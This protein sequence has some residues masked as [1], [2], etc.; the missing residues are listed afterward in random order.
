MLVLEF[1]FPAGRYHATPWGRN[2]NEGEVEW[3]PSP[4]RLA[5]ALVDVCHRRRPDWPDE[6]LAAVLRPLAAPPAFRLPPAT[7]SHTRSFLNS[8]LKDPTAKQ[9]IFD[10]FVAVDRRERLLVAFDCHVPEDV[11]TDLGDLLG[12]MNYLGRSESWVQARVIESTDGA[13]FNCGMPGSVKT[14]DQAERVR[15]ACLMSEQ[16]YASLPGQ[17]RRKSKYEGKK[18]NASQPLSWLDAIR[19]STTGLLTDGWSQPPA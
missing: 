3:P 19:L 1:Q 9:K 10:A 15:V 18:A 16:E 2:V 11:K 8:N 14:G 6:R 13:E 7:A 12:E 5:R 4:Y 17:P